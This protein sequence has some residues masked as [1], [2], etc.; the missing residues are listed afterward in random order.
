[1]TWMQQQ[2]QHINCAQLAERL[3]LRSMRSHIDERFL[4]WA[5]HVARKGEDSLAR[6]V[7]FGWCPHGKRAVGRP[8][9]TSRHRLVRLLRRVTDMVPVATRLKLAAH[10]WVALAKDRRQWRRLVEVACCIP[11]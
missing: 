1:M 2:V 5:G 4:M 6:Q 3:G 8:Q 11:P 9:Q 10:G 7:L